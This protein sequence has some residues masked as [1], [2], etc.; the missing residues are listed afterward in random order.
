MIYFL[1]KWA[2]TLLT[3][4]SSSHLRLKVLPWFNIVEEAR[5]DNPVEAFTHFRSSLIY[6]VLDLCYNHIRYGCSYVAKVA[7]LYSCYIFHIY[8]F[9]YSYS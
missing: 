3:V 7:Y 2:L 1:C 4:E 6:A 5:R 8:A 9:L